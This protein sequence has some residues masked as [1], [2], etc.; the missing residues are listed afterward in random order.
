[1]RRMLLIFIYGGE[2]W[3]K[4]CCGAILFSC[5]KFGEM[6]NFNNGPVNRTAMQMQVAQSASS[7]G[8]VGSNP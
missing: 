5:M 1:M 6:R 8:T 3:V 7:W 2:W 4:K